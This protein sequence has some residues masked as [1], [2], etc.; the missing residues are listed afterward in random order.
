MRLKGK[1]CQLVMSG[2]LYLCREICSW[3]LL[4]FSDGVLAFLM[5]CYFALILLSLSPPLPSLPLPLT[6]LSLPSLSLLPPLSSSSLSHSTSPS[7]PSPLPPFLSLSPHPQ[8]GTSRYMAPE[9]LEGAISFQR[10][11]YLRIDVYAFALILWELAS[12]TNLTNSK[13]T[14]PP[15]LI[16]CTSMLLLYSTVLR[17]LIVCT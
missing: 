12:R 2:F 7:S 4:F 15:P 10:E 16:S 8:V 1:Q 14:P 9:V 5:L 3:P 11:A 17:T 6:I 13:P